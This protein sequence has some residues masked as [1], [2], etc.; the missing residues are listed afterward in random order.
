MTQHRNRGERGIA[1]AYVGI[2]LLAMFS[3]IGLAV[4]LGRAYVIKIDLAKAVDAAALEGARQVSQGDA[5]AKAGALRAFALNFQNGY[6]GATL[7]N[8]APGA[9]VAT[10]TTV[11]GGINN[12][13]KQITVTQEVNLPTTFMRI[14]S[15]NSINVRASGQATRRLVD[16]A[17][18]IDHSGSLSGSYT[19]TP[20]VQQATTQFVNFFDPANDRMALIMFSTVASITDHMT[21]SRGFNKASILNHIANSSARDNTST[22]D[23]LYRGWDELHSVPNGQQSGLRAVVLFTDGAPNVFP[24]RFRYN[25]THNGSPFNPCAPATSCTPGG[26]L[27]GDFTPAQSAHLTG[28]YPTSDTTAYLNASPSCIAAT[29]GCW[30]T[31]NVSSPWKANTFTDIPQL[32]TNSFHPAPITLLVTGFPLYDPSPWGG[33]CG[34]CQRSLDGVTGTTLATMAGNPYADSVYNVNRASRNLVER[35]AFE[36]RADA[37][38]DQPIR[39]Y[40]LGLGAEL[41][42]NYGTVPETGASILQRVSND[43]SSPQYNP[44]QLDG[45]YYAVADPTQLNAAFA[46]VRDQ[47]IRVTQ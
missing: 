21:S 30:N 43:P 1:F 9:D 27:T 2:M 19:T 42:Q 39:I 24:A 16:V 31:N 12:G 23:A 20:G 14:A 22:A 32:P 3:F 25:L 17:F 29:S 38:G 40:T 41:N 10:V 37:S 46:Q 18:V 7:T 35:I 45:K 44:T 8:P 11:S 26:I 13:A 15:Y 5:A 47:L 6:L 36:I 34:P 4:D 28:L 33:T